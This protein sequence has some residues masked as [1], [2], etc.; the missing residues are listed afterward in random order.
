MPAEK[1]RDEILRTLSGAKYPVSATSLATKFSVSRQIIV[2]DIALLRASGK[3]ISATPKGY[4]IDG[5]Y[6]GIIRTIACKHS[7]DRVKDELY[8]IV[9]NGATIINVIV[10]HRVYGQMTAEIRLSNRYDVDKFLEKMDQEAPLLSVLTGGIHLHTI[11]CHDEN[12]YERVV[13]ALRRRDI[14]YTD[15]S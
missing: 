2:G 13:H 7:E 1:R 3:S 5:T 11:A 15:N 14:L 9:D 12:A 10:E 4:V 6:E 8:A